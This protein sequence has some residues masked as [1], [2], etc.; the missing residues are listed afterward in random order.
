LSLTGLGGSKLLMVSLGFAFEVEGVCGPAPQ[1][2]R[3]SAT[4]VARERISC[5]SVFHV[6]EINTRRNAKIC[7]WRLKLTYHLSVLI[8]SAWVDQVTVG[9]R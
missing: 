4:G 6:D 2:A 9:S 3:T 5:E 7:A 1:A 8:L